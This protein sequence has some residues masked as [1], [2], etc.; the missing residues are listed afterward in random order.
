MNYFLM[1]LG[2]FYLFEA[3]ANLF[4]WTDSRQPNNRIWQIGRAIRGIGGITLIGIG[5]WIF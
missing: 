1:G 5:A 4:Y 2:A 3:S